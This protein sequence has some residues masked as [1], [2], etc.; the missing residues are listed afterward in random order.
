MELF[1]NRSITA[2]MKASYDAMTSQPLRL[3][4]KTWWAVLADAVMTALCLYIRFPNKGLHDWGEESP[5]ASFVL[6]TVIFV[7]C[8]VTGILTGAAFWRWVN[9]KTLWHNLK[10]YL[11]IRVVSDL[12]ACVVALGISWA[13]TA[14]GGP[15]AKATVVLSVVMTLVVLLP[16]GYLQPRMMLLGEGEKLHPWRSYVTGI[17]HGGSIFMLGF[18]GALIVAVVTCVLFIPA[19]ILYGA[20]TLSQLG[21]LDGDPLGT[22]SYFTPLLLVVTGVLLFVFNYVGFWLSLAFAHLYG[23]YRA[24]EAER[25]E[26]EDN[27]QITSYQQ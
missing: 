3:L 12:V 9:R 1:K 8:A 23:S 17:R 14:V 15:V 26:M 10:R 11:A 27:K 20:Q 7:L 25:K 18:L 4:K 19:V 24:Q 6:Q 22:P 21:A 2:C 5:M 16:F 13:G